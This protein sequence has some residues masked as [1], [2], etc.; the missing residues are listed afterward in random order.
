MQILLEVK[1]QYY[2]SFAHE[3]I[4]TNFLHFEVK[5]ENF[6]IGCCIVFS[7]SCQDDQNELSHKTFEQTCFYLKKKDIQLRATY[8]CS[9]HTKFQI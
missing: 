3:C 2:L 5:N 7:S 8:N 4:R 9:L 6:D 1:Q